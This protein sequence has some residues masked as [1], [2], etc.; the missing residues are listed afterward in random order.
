MKSAL[1]LGA[2]A[3]AAATTLVHCASQDEHPGTVEDAGRSEDA[4]SEA[5]ADAGADADASDAATEDEYEI[6]DGSVSCEASPC[7]VALG[8]S[9]E[10]LGTFCA[11]LDDKTVQC[12][13]S[14]ILQ[15]LGYVPAGGGFPMSTT[16]HR[17]PNLS[18]VTSLSVG[19]Y[20]AC[21]RVEDGSVFCWGQDILV[22]AGM[23]PDAGPVSPG[24]ALPTRMDLVPLAKDVAVGTQTAC[25]TSATGG[26]SC[27]GRNTASQLA[28]PTSEVGGPSEI[29]V[30]G[31]SI[32]LAA[33][34]QDA[35]FAVTTSGELLSWGGARCINVSPSCAYLLGRGTSEDPDPVPTLV[36]DL[37]KVRA[38]AP[39]SRYACAIAGRHVECWGGNTNGELGRGFVTDVSKL[40]APTILSRVTEAEDADAGLPHRADIPLQIVGNKSK[41]CAVMGSGRVYCWGPGQP[42]SERGRPTRVDGL[43]G[44]VVALAL[45]E[46][47]SCALLRS[48][49]V[50]CWGGNVVGNLGRGIDDGFLDQEWVDLK[51]APVT[52]ER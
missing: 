7:V 48:G 31:R 40:P 36:P 8:G 3:I 16:P 17:L 30:G 14:N 13:G 2:V 52:F 28:R 25:V 1:T 51:P 39:A 26:L 5:E 32:A 43:S 47:T 20:N 44:P 33:P 21:A 35:M 29:P 11:L 4:A 46:N 12:W 19:G 45:N 24:G 37:S 6:P 34:G 18:G 9:D 27:W 49:V 42:P 23:S 38:V 10:A 15:R 50:E 22:G 41:T